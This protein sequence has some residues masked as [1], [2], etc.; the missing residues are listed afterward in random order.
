MGWELAPIV[1]RNSSAA[2][3]VSF[4]AGRAEVSGCHEP[5]DQLPVGAEGGPA[6][7]RA[8]PGRQA[9]RCPL[10]LAGSPDR[11]VSKLYVVNLRR[12]RLSFGDVD[13]VDLFHL[14]AKPGVERLVR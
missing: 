13:A 1:T 9:R 5:H 12:L 7:L 6:R 11:G 10:L 8:L 4:P 2:S 3:V 14:L